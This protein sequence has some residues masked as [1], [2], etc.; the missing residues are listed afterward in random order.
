MLKSAIK[1]LSMLVALLLVSSVLVCLAETETET[2]ISSYEPL[3]AQLHTVYTETWEYPVV[4]GVRGSGK[5]IGEGSYTEAHTFG[6]DGVCIYCGYAIPGDIY[7][8]DD[9]DGDGETTGTTATEETGDETSFTTASGVTVEKGT[10]AD[11]VLKTVVDS[12]PTDA[13]ISNV[14]A[15]TAEALLDAINNGV[16]SE[17]LLE[18]LKDFPIQTVD[19][20]E[21]YIVAFAYKD[22][23]GNAVTEN[24]AFSTVDGTLVKVF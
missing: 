4:D 5:V 9:D 24:F 6:D 1:V 7:D 14:D 16:T 8:G 3:N 2:Y 21:C 11:K 22:A 10:K 15:D 20:I 17:E 12:L 13:E 23:N 19:G 18:I